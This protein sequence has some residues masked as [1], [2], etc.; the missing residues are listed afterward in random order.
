MGLPT[1]KLRYVK[2]SKD[3]AKTFNTTD[4]LRMWDIL[5]PVFPEYAHTSSKYPTLSKEPLVKLLKAKGY[6]VTL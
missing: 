1:L 5:A 3:M 2:G 6:I 4:D